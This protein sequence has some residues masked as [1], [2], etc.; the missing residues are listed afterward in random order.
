[1]G[2]YLQKYMS[3]HQTA[4]PFH[5]SVLKTSSVIRDIVKE[6]FRYL[7]LLPDKLELKEER[8]LTPLEQDLQIKRIRKK[9]GMELFKTPLISRKSLRR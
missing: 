7:G 5:S 9:R 6:S 3:N 4:P 1:M 8:S 2:L